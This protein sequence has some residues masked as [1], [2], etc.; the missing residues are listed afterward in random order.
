MKGDFHKREGEFSKCL[1]TEH[2]LHQRCELGRSATSGMLFSSSLFVV[3][4]HEEEIH[5]IVE[6]IK[7]RREKQGL[8]STVYTCCTEPFPNTFTFSAPAEAVWIGWH[9]AAGNYDGYLRWAYN[10]WTESPLQDSRF[11][12][13]AA[14]DCYLVYPDGRSSIR[15]ERLIEGIQEYEKIQL[16]KQKWENEPQKLAQLND[17]IRTFTIQSKGN[18]TTEEQVRRAK[19][20]L[21]SI[22]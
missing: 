8:K 2:R 9:A 16:L 11:R 18:Q 12:S 10:S 22:K 17:I 20:V 5:K 19:A 14:G 4:F 6:K 15:F 7:E 3:A 1:A 21:N 13:W